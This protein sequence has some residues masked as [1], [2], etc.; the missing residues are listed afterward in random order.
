MVSKIRGHWSGVVSTWSDD[1]PPSW[2]LGSVH[3]CRAKPSVAAQSRGDRGEQIQ[4]RC[5]HEGRIQQQLGMGW[6]DLVATRVG[7]GRSDGDLLEEGGSSNN[8]GRVGREDPSGVTGGNHTTW[9]VPDRGFFMERGS[10]TASSG[11]GRVRPRSPRLLRGWK[12]GHQD[13]MRR[14]PVFM[15][16]NLYGG[17]HKGESRGQHIG[18]QGFLD[19][20]GCPGG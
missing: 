18:T 5:A 17:V 1:S 16:M 20:F 19:K 7:A 4:W 9:N 6:A 10:M 3:R 11:S 14:L 2:Q 13:Y 12:R 8:R 15:K